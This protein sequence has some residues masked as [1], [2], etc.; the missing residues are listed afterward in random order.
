[1]SLINWEGLRYEKIRIANLMIV[2]EKSEADCVE[3]TLLER[4]AEFQE[5]YIKKATK[6]PG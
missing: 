5:S 3:P 4:I 2:L 1:M 6:S